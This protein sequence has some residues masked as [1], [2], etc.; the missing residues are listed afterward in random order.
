MQTRGGAMQQEERPRI[1][2]RPFITVVHRRA[3]E[4]DEL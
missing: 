4:G 2:A 3:I 1:I